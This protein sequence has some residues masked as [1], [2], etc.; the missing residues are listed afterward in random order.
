MRS[1]SVSDTALMVR[2]VKESSVNTGNL[3][4]SLVSFVATTGAVIRLLHLSFFK[5]ELC[6]LP[7]FFLVVCGLL[8]LQAFIHPITLEFIFTHFFKGC[9]NTRLSGPCN[10][11]S[12]EQVRSRS[13]ES[14]DVAAR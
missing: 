11:L 4:L 12:A 5:C 2:L 10:T 6:I 14:G 3:D 13:A 8:S 9:G 1:H 7:F